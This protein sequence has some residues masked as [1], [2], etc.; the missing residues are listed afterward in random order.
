MA[1]PL[2]EEVLEMSVG[3]MSIESPTRAFL[4]RILLSQD[5]Y[6]RYPGFTLECFNWV[7]RDVTP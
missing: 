7:N 1:R 2:T 3:A 5:G 4:L 6:L